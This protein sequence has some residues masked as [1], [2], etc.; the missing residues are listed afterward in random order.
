MDQNST[1][2]VLMPF[3]TEFDDVYEYL[4][5]GA[6]SEAGFNVIRADDIRNQ[7]NILADI[8]EG[9]VKSDLVIADLST[10]NP[11]VYYELGLA[12]ALSKPVILL[13]QEINDVPFDLRSYR[14]LTY[15][16]HFARINEARSELYELA[17]GAKKKN[18]L[19]GNPISDFTKLSGIGIGA[20][21]PD[22]DSSENE[23][24][25][26]DK[27][28]LDFQAEVE[29]GFE[30]ITSIM[31]EVGERF[32]VLGPEVITATEQLQN[33]TETSR[34]RSIVRTL[35]ASMDGYAKWL[36]QGNARYRLSLGQISESLDAIFSGEFE[37]E[38]VTISELQEFAIALKETEMAAAN[39]QE[40]ISVLVATID[41]LPRIE[42]E[43]NRAKRNIS[44][45][46]KELLKNVEQTIAVLTRARNAAIFLYGDSTNN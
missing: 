32:N 25:Y 23:L 18:T 24:K 38:G 29:E 26:S 36:Q 1:A 17:K 35:A 42:R 2:F 6:L 33:S 28:V 16:T 31:E 40:A 37:E 45:E 39:G 9:I 5:K 46:L 14:I 13:A 22:K 20:A 3:A 21:F 27:G 41:G 10:T 44:D 34:R 19:F 4:I 12:H 11:N 8:V 15:T 43:F 7:R 30:V